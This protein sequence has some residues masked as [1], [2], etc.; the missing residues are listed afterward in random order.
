MAA[1]SPLTNTQQ[2]SLFKNISAST[3]IDTGFGNVQAIVINSHSSGIIKIWDSLTASGTVM[4]DQMTLSTVATTGERW[5][6]LF[7]AEFVTGLYI[8]LVSGTAN[9][10]VIWN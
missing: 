7:G 8:Q 9:L 10:T 6:P 2:A 3:L 4:F 5:I 1:Y